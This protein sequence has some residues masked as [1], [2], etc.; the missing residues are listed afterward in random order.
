MKFRTLL[1]ILAIVAVTLLI[2]DQARLAL[3]AALPSN[4]PGTARFVQTGYDVATNEA[5]GQWIGCRPSP[6]QSSDWCRVTDQR[7][8]VVFEGQFLPVD[9][10]ALVP[11]EGLQFAPIDKGRLWTYGPAEQ[12]PVP[13]IPLANGQ[14]LVPVADR[15]AL[16]TRWANDPDEK[17]LQA[18]N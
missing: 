10:T 15:P 7:G 17:Y 14:L 5:L 18:R 8:S 13:V 4:M 1:A 3:H 2:A 9:S 12:A 16:L 6:Q 11:V